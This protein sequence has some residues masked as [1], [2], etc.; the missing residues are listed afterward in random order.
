[1]PTKLI[2]PIILTLTNTTAKVKINNKFN[3]E[4]DVRCG[5]KQGDP[6]SASFLDW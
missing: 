6:L 4:F 5:V 1:V 3:E 2:E